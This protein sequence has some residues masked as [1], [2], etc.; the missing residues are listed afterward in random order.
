MYMQH[1]QNNIIKYIIALAI[2]IVGNLF[3]FEL[4]RTV[5][6]EPLYEDYCGHEISSKA[7]TVEA[8]C[9]S[10]GGMWSANTAFDTTKPVASDNSAGWCDATY[11][12]NKTYQTDLDTYESKTFYLVFVFSMLVLIGG[13]FFTVEQTIVRLGLAGAGLVGLVISALGYW[14]NFSNIA[15]LVLMAVALGALL[16]VSAKKMRD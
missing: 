12:C 16:W 9:T 15:R 11:T 8:D 14:D 10:G 1:F 13:M 3:V 6:H 7:I 5:F 2:V 4:A